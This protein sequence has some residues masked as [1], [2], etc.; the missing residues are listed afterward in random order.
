MKKLFFVQALVCLLSVSCSVQEPDVK[1]IASPKDDVFYA[2]LESYSDPDTKVYVDSKVKLHWD[3]KDLISIFNETTLNQKYQFTGNT[4]DTDGLFEK[5]E[6]P[7]GTGNPLKYVCAV[8]PHSIYTKINNAG[9]MTL[10]LPAEQAY[11]E[12]SFGPG[13]NLMISC[14]EGDPLE[15]KNACGYLVL[16]FYGEG[17]AVSSV[18]L[19]GNDGEP[20][21]G[22]ATW[23]PSVGTIPTVK[24]DAAAETSVSL[25]CED[26]VKLEAAKENATMFWMVVP[27][28]DFAN[29]FTL[30]VTGPDGKTF[31]KKTDLQLPIV[32]NGVLRIAPIEVKF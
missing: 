10:N 32:R 18:K 4:G 27:P 15:F 3:A 6:D 22:K 21:S 30:T 16:K 7:F 24:M 19:E 23:S 1:D 13:A 14:T 31:V 8:Y 29:G 17:V 5:A 9:V 2:S 28:T 11:R 20:L 25:I 12:G 26:E